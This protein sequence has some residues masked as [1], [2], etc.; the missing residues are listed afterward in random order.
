[1]GRLKSSEG[2][3]F[4]FNTNGYTFLVW[5]G[6]RHGT[7]VQEDVAANGQITTGLRN[8]HNEFYITSVRIVYGFQAG[9]Y[10]VLIILP[11]NSIID[12]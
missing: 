3:V 8:K 2:L 9:A 4:P 12:M 10:D 11:P 7:N 6:P 5:A 1:M